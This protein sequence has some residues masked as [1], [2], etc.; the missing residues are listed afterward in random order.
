MTRSALAVIGSSSARSA[1]IASLSPTFGAT[2]GCLRRVSE[3]R[4]SSTASLACRYSTSQ[5]MPLRRSS[6]TS[7]GTVSISF[8]RLRASSPTAVR[9]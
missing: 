2:S 5:R 8:G 3:K 6:V 9:G 1:A 7:A 4:F